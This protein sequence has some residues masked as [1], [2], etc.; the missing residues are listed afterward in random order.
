MEG[1][2]WGHPVDGLRGRKWLWKL[3]RKDIERFVQQTIEQRIVSA[4]KTLAHVTPLEEP[5]RLIDT[6]AP[7]ARS[8]TLHEKQ[9]I[10]ETVNLPERARLLENLL[11][12]GPDHYAELVMTARWLINMQFR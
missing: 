8:L 7:L 11:A 1:T 6:I 5:G 4:K 9:E 12:K 3:F 2:P 10:L